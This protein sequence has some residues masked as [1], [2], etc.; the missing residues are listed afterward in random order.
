MTECV[1]DIE[2]RAGEDC[3]TLAL[4]GELT[5]GSTEALRACIEQLAPTWRCVILDMQDVT[6][7]DSS[8]I[9]ALLQANSV[10]GSEFRRMELHNLPE[11]VRLVF[12]ITGVL[13]ILTVRPDPDATPIPA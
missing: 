7:V 6:F 5:M 9:A 3:V 1:L 2:V 11:R 10:L 8:G 4:T 12:E 13:E